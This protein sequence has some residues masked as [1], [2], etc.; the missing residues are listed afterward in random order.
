MMDLQN[1]LGFISV[2]LLF[3]HCYIRILLVNFLLKKFSKIFDLL[4][5]IYNYLL[6]F[7]LEFFM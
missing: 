4:L 7:L 3:K 2:R 1:L 6:L 5:M